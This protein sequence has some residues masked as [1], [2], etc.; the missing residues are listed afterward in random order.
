MF[1]RGCRSG[2]EIFLP[3]Q[4][5]SEAGT[6]MIKAAFRQ[7]KKRVFRLDL[8]QSSVQ[9]SF[10]LIRSPGPTTLA[11]KVSRRNWSVHDFHPTD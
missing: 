2:G 4:H 5:L 11:S 9:S 10:L 6:A 7:V 3:G 1:H 8:L